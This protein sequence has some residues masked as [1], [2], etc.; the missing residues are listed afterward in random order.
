MITPA[1]PRPD[2]SRARP[3][4]TDAADEG[5]PTSP[6]ALRLLTDSHRRTL[7]VASLLSLTAAGLGLAQPLLALHAIDTTHSGGSLVLP[8]TLLAVVF[9]A[10]ALTEGLA[11][12]VLE[13]TGESIVLSLRLKMIARL[14]R[15]RMR[16]HDNLRTGDLV[17]RV[18]TDTTLLRDAVAYGS[19]DILSGTVVVLGGASVMIWLD[20]FLFLLVCAVLAVAGGAAA[21][22]LA[23]VR[24][25][26]EHAQ[27]SVG[28]MSADL[29]RAMTAI[30]TVRASRAT[31]RESE[32]I[33]ARARAAWTAGV[34]AAR[35]DSLI[36]PAV[37]L[38]ANGSFIL[39]LIVG[40]IQVA[41]GVIPLAH[42]IA[43][44]LYITYLAVPLSGLFQAA[45]LVQKGRGALARARGVLQLPVEEAEPATARPARPVTLLLR[46][47]PA[48]CPEKAGP[49][50]LEM[51]GVHFAY[52]DRQVLR[53][54][55]F[56]VPHRS[57]TAV[58]GPSGAGKSTLFALIARFYDPDSGTIRLN[59]HNTA[60]LTRTECRSH[61]GLVEQDSP[62]LHGTLRD[63]LAYAAPDAPEHEI[64]RAVR[65]ANLQELL[66]RLPDGLDTP[67]GDHG[68]LLSG[69]ERQRLAIA[70]ALLSRP[71]LLL[72]DEP[73]AHMDTINEA[74]LARTI[75]H[76]AARTALLIIAHRIST[77]RAAD[78]IIVLDDGHV[79]A[80]GTH[81]HLRTASALY[82][83]L[84]G[85]EG[86]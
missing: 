59:G 81:E 76:I 43:F 72:L 31:D 23:R 5:A 6:S 13:R 51:E 3:A 37:E 4:A 55:S 8:V 71:T 36:S 77:V 73:T 28:E 56:R 16:E 38:A 15:L 65:L 27:H 12:Y 66:Q 84:T 10:Q 78:Q 74:G 68:V 29:E 60:D 34:R 41:H 26:T 30:R 50:A 58:V 46:A 48:S 82:R 40:G 1:P 54:V 2:N 67:V 33:G 45:A 53:D 14:L 39:V 83:R 49:P 63:N 25:V 62:I 61:I 9:I 22:A 47:D 18:S 86:F 19:V 42:L 35:L 17:S 52:R 80:A 57:R 44:L 20:P 75:E 32:R 79:E 70:R 69:G 11:H 24:D 7:A 85:A 64:H 21:L